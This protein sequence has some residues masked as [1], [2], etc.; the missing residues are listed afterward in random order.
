[1]GAIQDQGAVAGIAIAI[2][3]GM[4]LIAGVGFGIYSK[5]LPLDAGMAIFIILITITDFGLSNSIGSIKDKDSKTNALISL[6]VLNSIAVIALMLYLG[7]STY[8]AF[9]KTSIQ[10]NYKY[11][12]VLI[13]VCVVISIVSLSATAMKQLTR[14]HCT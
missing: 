1:M 3:F 6:I 9:Q 2:I 7:V 10:M 4:A 13:P 5:K 12:H 14:A 11:I 8:T